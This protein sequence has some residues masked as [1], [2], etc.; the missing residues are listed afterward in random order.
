MPLVAQTW[1]G[2]QLQLFKKYVLYCQNINKD[3]VF[4]TGSRKLAMSMFA[5]SLN[6][7]S[8][9]SFLPYI[10]SDQHW[11]LNSAYISNWGITNDLAFMCSY[12]N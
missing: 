4:R 2:L 12:Y 8:L 5:T 11:F 1:H 9:T 7:Y 10:F 3:L 6:V